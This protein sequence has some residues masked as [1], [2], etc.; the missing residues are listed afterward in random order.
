MK[1]LITAIYKILLLYEDMGK[2]NSNVTEDDY[3]R[4]LD[5][6]YIRFTGLENEEVTSS[7]RG[8]YFLGTE[9][10]HASV[11]SMVFHLIDVLE[12]EGKE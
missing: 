4:Y 11:K 1:E 10:D 12:K 6:L 7:I 3:R 5:R 8:L 2:P 9:A